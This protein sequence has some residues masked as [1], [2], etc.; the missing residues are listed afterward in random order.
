VTAAGRG[1]LTS[2]PGLEVKGAAFTTVPD[3]V[4]IHSRSFTPVHSP[5][6]SVPSDSLARMTNLSAEDLPPTEWRRFASEE[7][8][9]ANLPEPSLDDPVSVGIM[10]CNALEDPVQY[11]NALLRL[12]T[13]ESRPAWGD[14][15]EASR[16][17]TSIEDLGYGSRTEPAAG[18]DNVHYFKIMQGITQSYEVLEDQVVFLKGV[19]TLVWRPKHRQWMVHAIGGGYTRPEDVPH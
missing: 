18:D 2:V 19:L 1:A 14:F 4:F 17:I 8:A 9:A 13:P 16:F 15:G 5:A 6:Q 12:V 11:R 10:F 3:A 7:E